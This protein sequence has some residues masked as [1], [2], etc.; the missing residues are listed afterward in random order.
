MERE[1]LC[2][3]TTQNARTQLADLLNSESR[4]VEAGMLED[5]SQVP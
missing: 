3:E 5:S 2:L 4:C 1:E